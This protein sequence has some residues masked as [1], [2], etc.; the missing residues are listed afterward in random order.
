MLLQNKAAPVHKRGWP[1]F[2]VMGQL[3]AGARPQ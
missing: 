3:F 1:R 2:D